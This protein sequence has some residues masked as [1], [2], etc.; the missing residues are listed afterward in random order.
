[1][2]YEWL[3]LQPEASDV[4]LSTTL[5]GKVEITGQADGQRRLES[6][7]LHGKP[8]GSSRSSGPL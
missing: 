6:V 2:L 3:L 5:L 7:V 8:V 4:K 1:M